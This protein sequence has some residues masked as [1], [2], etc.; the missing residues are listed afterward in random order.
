MPQ[1][2]RFTKGQLEG[3][4]IPAAGTRSTHYDTEVQKLAIR[5]TAW[6]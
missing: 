3:L 5:I 4:P 6:R 2:I 1:R